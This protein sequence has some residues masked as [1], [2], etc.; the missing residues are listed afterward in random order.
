M[1]DL[2]TALRDLSFKDTKCGNFDI[3]NPSPI[4]L[5]SYLGQST[6]WLM[7]SEELKA[8]P[9]EFQNLVSDKAMEIAVCN[10]T[11]SATEI[12]KKEIFI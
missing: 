1:R 7:N 2:Y 4:R 11:R 8:F 12:F 10:R 5:L 9:V 3:E 6:E